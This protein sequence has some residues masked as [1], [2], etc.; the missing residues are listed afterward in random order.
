MNI[1]VLGGGGVGAYIAAK[2]SRVCDVDLISDLTKEILLKEQSNITRYDV[3]TYTIPPQEKRYD[4]VIIATKSNVLLQKLEKMKK[5]IDKKS[6][7]LPLLNGIQPY[8]LLK[9]HLPSI[10]IPGAVYIISNKQDDGTIEVKGKGAMVV[11][12]DIN[13]T[14]HALKECFEKAGIKTKTPKNIMQAIW[15]KYLFIAATAA[16]TTY[17][18]KTF[19]EIATKHIDEFQALLEEIAQ[20]ARNE[21]VE[22]HEEDIQK[23]ITLLRKSPANAKTSLQLDFEKGQSG[24]LDNLLGYLAQKMPSG[25]IASIYKKLLELIA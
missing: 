18:H 7:I 20:I 6:I 23:A 21:N 13:E 3:S 15:Q 19:G 22:L 8:M 12:E 24:E 25:K 10:V 17:Y 16:L 14:T 1:A 11:F 5:N 4:V 9:K 2:L